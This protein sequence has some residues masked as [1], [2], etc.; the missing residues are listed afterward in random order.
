MQ[1]VRLAGSAPSRDVRLPMRR[2]VVLVWKSVPVVWA[3]VPEPGVGADERP[4]DEFGGVAE[5]GW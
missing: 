5:V 4:L 2:L 1:E 3:A